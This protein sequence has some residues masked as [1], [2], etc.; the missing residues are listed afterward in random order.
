MAGFEVTLGGWFWV[1]A[2]TVV[3]VVYM[4]IIGAIGLSRAYRALLGGGMRPMW[5]TNLS[6]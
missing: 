1:T 2:D 5:L 6:Y 4:I 3:H